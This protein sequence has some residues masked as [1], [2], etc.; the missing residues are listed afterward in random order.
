MILRKTPIMFFFLILFFQF[1]NCKNKIKDTFEASDSI[2][3]GK[4]L[5]VDTTQKGGIYG[6]FHIGYGLRLENKSKD[7]VVVFG[8][9]IQYIY[10]I[11]SKNNS[12]KDSIWLPPFP[13]FLAPYEVD[14]FEVSLGRRNNI[15]MGIDDVRLEYLFN[16]K[17]QSDC[18][19]DERLD[20]L[21]VVKKLV[22]RK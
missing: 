1:I 18:P 10:V 19:L 5:Y 21:Y 20:S 22:F 3:E 7:S 11:D 15:N 6:A 4:I 17:S 8:C 12:I 16:L 13:S 9:G 14:S 2:V